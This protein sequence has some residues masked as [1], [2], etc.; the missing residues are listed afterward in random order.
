VINSLF[1]NH[2][3]KNDINKSLLE[4]FEN[5]A[6]TNTNEQL[7]LISAPLSEEKY[8]YEYE[9]NAIV[10]LSPKHKII[11][12]DLQSN[13]KAFEEYCEDFIE[14]L[15]SLS[16]KYNYKRHIGRPREWKDELLVYEDTKPVDLN[17]FFKQHEINDT[18]LRR[19][20]ELLISLLIGSIN[21]IEKIGV[22]VPKTVLEKVKRNIIL[23]DGD[24]TR[25][26]YKKFPKKTVSIQGLSGTGKTELLLHKLKELYIKDDDTKIFFTCHNKTLARYLKE[27]I[28]KFFDFMK[29]EKQIEWHDRLWVDIAWGSEKYPNTG[30]YSYICNFYKF[31]FMRYRHGIGYKEIFTEALKY[32]DTIKD[33]DEFEYAFDYVL[34]DERQDFPK[35]F[36]ELCE[37]VTKQQVY[38][39]GDIFQDIWDNTGDDELEVDIVLNRCYR[40]DPRTLMFA[41]ALGMGLFESKKLNWL[42]DSQWEEIGY[43]IQRQP[44]RTMCLTRDPIRRFEDLEHEDVPS[45]I[46]EKQTS[47]TQIV[48]LLEKIKD[49]NPTVEPNDVAIIIV[50]DNKSIYEFID[51][52]G[53]KITERLGW[54]INRAYDTKTTIDNTIFISNRNNVKGLEFPFVICITGNIKDGYRYRNSLYTMLT[55]SFIQSYLLVTHDEGI[56]IQKRGLDIINSHRFIQTTEPTDEEKETI[57]QTVIKMKKEKNISYEEFLR[58]IFDELKIPQNCR[59]KL[60]KGLMDFEIEEFNEEQTKH[61]IDQNRSFCK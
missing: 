35:E 5:Y 39:A 16:D 34:I 46:I 29:V 60:Q 20:T 42:S 61:Y 38:I 26:I 50:D 8:Q 32:I 31:P 43:K 48:D 17:V 4:E 36:F 3:E 52:L 18:N 47:I 14:D 55:R 12:L 1:F 27:R 57:R 54:D 44:N 22:N 59:K 51:K 6:K 28:P 40:T 11:F 49:N 19:K 58:K 21:N 15:T 2:I 23:F 33:T 25:F 13:K 30:I 9:K 10:I 41:H 56:E 7:Y 24:Q 37:K 53:Y 45:M